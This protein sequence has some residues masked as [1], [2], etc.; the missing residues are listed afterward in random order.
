[1]QWRSALS[2]LLSILPASRSSTTL[3]TPSGLFIVP[4]SVSHHQLIPLPMPF[5]IL[6]MA[7]RVRSYN[8]LQVSSTCFMPTSRMSV[9]ERRGEE[10]EG[11]MRIAQRPDDIPTFDVIVGG[12]GRIIQTFSDVYPRLWSNRCILVP[13]QRMTRQDFSHYAV[14]LLHWR[15]RWVVWY[16]DKP[17]EADHGLPGRGIPP[18]LNREAGPLSG[19]RWAEWIWGRGQGCWFSPG[20]SPHLYSALLLWACLCL[21][22]GIGKTGGGGGRIV[23]FAG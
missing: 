11:M 6:V 1:M 20:T 8:F 3:Y 23:V 4:D 18:P 5:S 10:E 16:H 15:D 13:R 17:G 19:G 12:G 2:L 14:A 22:R 9:H 7:A 21:W